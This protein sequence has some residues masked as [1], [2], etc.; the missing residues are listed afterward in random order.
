MKMLG[1]EHDHAVPGDPRTNARA[2]RAN[3]MVLEGARSILIYAGL[4][5]QFW[6]YACRYFCLA[7]NSMSWKGHESAYKLRFGEQFPVNKPLLPFGC[8]VYFMPAEVNQDRKVSLVSSS[9][10]RHKLG[11]E[12]QTQ[13]LW[14][15]LKNSTR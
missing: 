6:P 2:E 4:P 8:L 12:S 14:W 5:T 3:R 11:V 15:T 13:E 1:T 7:H 10:M 9:D